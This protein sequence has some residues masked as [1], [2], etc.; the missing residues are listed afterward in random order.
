[1]VELLRIEVEG[2][3]RWG[4]RQPVPRVSPSSS[5]SHNFPYESLSSPCKQSLYPSRIRPRMCSCIV[6]GVSG[7][8]R[9]TWTPSDWL[10]KDAGLPMVPFSLFRES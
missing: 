9:S 5:V 8:A 1:L 4:A 10:W 2:L 3:H 6:I 7:V